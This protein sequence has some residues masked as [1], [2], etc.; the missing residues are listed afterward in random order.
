M[1]IIKD[2]KFSNFIIKW[3]KTLVVVSGITTI[4]V[5]ILTQVIDFYKTT[6]IVAQNNFSS[7]SQKKE[8]THN[9]MMDLIRGEE[10]ETRIEMSRLLML[11]NSS[12]NKIEIQDMNLELRPKPST[13]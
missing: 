9:E 10:L 13:R 12:N 1:D 11:L 3:K 4:V 6:R 7:A 8:L 2:N 5:G